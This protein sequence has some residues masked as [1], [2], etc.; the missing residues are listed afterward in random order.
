M[1][2]AKEK[3]AGFMPEPTPDEIEGGYVCAICWRPIEE[4]DGPKACSDC[5]GDAE[6]DQDAVDE[7]MA[8]H[9]QFGAA[10]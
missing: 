4:A 6:I 8:E 10:A 9:G 3:Y 1:G 2:S 7:I 5:G